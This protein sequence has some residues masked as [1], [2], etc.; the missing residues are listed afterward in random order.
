MTERD[1]KIE[2][3]YFDDCPS[4]KKTFDIL[5]Q[6]L[7]KLGI[8]QDVALIPVETQEDA[9]KNE[10]TGSPTIRVNGVDLFPT[11]QSNYALGC[12]LYQTPQGFKGWPTEEM[13]SDKLQ[14]LLIRK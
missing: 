9:V 1:M 3:L 14:T 4:W 8:L 12:R 10:F 2:L 13:I 11:G 7:K 5:D 6:S